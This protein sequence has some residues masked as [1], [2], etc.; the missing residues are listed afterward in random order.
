VADR[1]PRALNLCA[2]DGDFHPMATTATTLAGHRHFDLI[3]S[4]TADYTW[5]F[6]ADL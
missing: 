5:S 1:N 2:A 6:K 3:A 4:Q